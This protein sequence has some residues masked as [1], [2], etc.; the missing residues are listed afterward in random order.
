MTPHY[1]VGNAAPLTKLPKTFPTQI[2]ENLF[3]GIDIGIGSCG[4]ALISHSKAKLTIKGFEKL[5]GAISFMGV[6]AFDVPEIKE[7][8]GI[9]L[10][11]P[12]RRQKRLMRRVLARR[13]SR[14]KA[15]K[16]LLIEA[17]ILPADYS[18]MQ[19]AWRGRH[20]AA[21]P[22]KWRVEALNRKLSDWEFA[23]ILMHYAKR[24]GFKSAKK[25]DLESK[26]SEGGT[27]QSSRANHAALANYLTVADMLSRDPRF[28]I[29]NSA[30]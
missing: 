22:W 5:P 13:A 16:A 8:S 17:K 29:D 18:P 15:V 1:I 7:K 9:V 20:E 6:R 26:G 2:D 21:T 4:I 25:S 24:R 14:M 19:D 3:C 27:L 10:K 23:V 30:P 28:V 11:N 12:E